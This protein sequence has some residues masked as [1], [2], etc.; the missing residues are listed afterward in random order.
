MSSQIPGFYFDPEKKKYFK[1][2]P[3][4][5]AP[6][7]AS[8]SRES[9]KRRRLEQKEKQKKAA[10][11][12]RIARERVRKNGFLHHPLIGADREVGSQPTSRNLR[13]EQYA[14]IYVSQ[15]GRRKVHEFK[16][17]PDEYSIRNLI[18]H[19]DSGILIAG[20]QRGQG[21]AVSLCFPDVENDNWTYNQE[22]ER[23]LLKD[24]Y[25][26]SSLSQSHTGFLL[27]T[28][29]SGPRGDSFLAPLML[30]APDQGGDYSQP[31]NL[32]HPIRIP[33]KSSLWC[34]AACPTGPKAIFAI[35]TSEGLC[36]LE[37]YGSRWGVY[38]KQF[39]PGTVRRARDSSHAEVMGLDW[40][41]SDVIACGLRSSAI[42]LHDMR[43]N[44]STMRLQHP[45]TIKKVRKLD[46]Y[47]LL[48]AGFN[49]LQM[50]DLRYA[51]NGIQPIPLPL[52]RSHTSTRPYVT[53]PEYSPYFFPDFD[54]SS[55]L[56][57]LASEPN[58]FD[59]D[60]VSKDHRVQ[61][62][63]L[64]TG[65]TVP[66]PISNYRYSEP[67]TSVLFES[68]DEDLSPYGPQKPSLLVASEAQV[69]QWIW[70]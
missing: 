49:S 42:F 15:L 41:S 19:Q 48:V 62:F 68:G 61:L 47:R 14:R 26:L 69:D 45:D 54:L 13:Q 65:K 37:G 64:N 36:T 30:P 5:I 9:V 16:P 18:R 29:D 10:F 3:N 20:G 23:V 50:Y 59:G 38:R 53:F 32:I 63:S 8:Y 4:H 7:G 67:A 43:S 2:Q 22:M 33:G 17:W 25:R 66:S 58:Q 46:P 35:G 70:K 21:S 27:A 39:P 60:K 51:P 44:G 52:S 28:M 12:Q 11:D 57:L 55:E 24:L 6:A 31:S 34:S 40:I 1:I 56:G